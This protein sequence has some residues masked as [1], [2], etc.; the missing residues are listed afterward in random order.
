MQTATPT[1]RPKIV[2]VGGG[3]GGITAAQHLSK[4]AGSCDITL[5]SKDPIFEYYPALYK[6]VTGAL[7]IEV[8][9]PLH[10]ITRLRRVAIE[11]GTFVKNDTARRVIMLEG[12]KEI[13]Y[14]YLVLALGSET[15]YFNIPGLPEL[16]YSFKS[17]KEALR[18]KRHFC[19]LF[20]AAVG[21]KKEDAVAKLHTVIVGG[22]PSGVELAG[23]L[24]HYLRDLARTFTLD[25]SLVTIDLIEAANRILPTF[26]EK[27]SRKAD[28]R[29]RM[30]GVN[31]YT[32]RA[33]MEQDINEV[34]M[35]SMNFKSN[36]VIWTAGTRINSAYQAVSGVT[37]TDRKRV[38]V[39]DFLALPHDD[40]VFVIGD[41]AGTKHSG[42]AQTA[43]Y[44]GRYIARHITTLLKGSKPKPY[45][46][47]RVSYLVSVGNWWALFVSGN[48]IFKG[49]LPWIMR[50]A[51]DLRY[52]LSIMPL[53][54]VI[55]VIRKG[56]NYRHSKTYCPME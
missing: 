33:V 46:P 31:I 22:G 41:G 17:V 44:D 9:L 49:A 14:D 24:T 7:A 47:P 25:P 32:N 23:D 20:S 12:G 53:R 40:R 13:A 43:I 8:S 27:A 37:F 52:L 50:T 39:N 10:N 28:K 38:D 35:G 4:R 18:L 26:S 45:V 11:Q 2:I 55:A 34:S 5:I 1:T 21:M 42:L 6:L 51:V 19:D 30:L 29:L 48:K 56:H 16:S 36:T 15:N 3:F 54:H